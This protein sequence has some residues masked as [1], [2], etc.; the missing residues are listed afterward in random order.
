VYDMVV[1][2]VTASRPITIERCNEGRRAS[3]WRI[4]GVIADERGD[5]DGRGDLDM[6]GTGYLRSGLRDGEVGVDDATGVARGCVRAGS[7]ARRPT[8]RAPW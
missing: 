6:I 3:S 8:G 4:L 5:R 1:Q 7:A 2:A